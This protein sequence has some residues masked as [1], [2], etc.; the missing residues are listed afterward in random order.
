MTRVNYPFTADELT[1]IFD[2][3]NVQLD[4]EAGMFLLKSEGA[5]KSEL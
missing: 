1:E 3:M 4:L 2:Q 5:E